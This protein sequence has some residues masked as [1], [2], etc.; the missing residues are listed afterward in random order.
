LGLKLQ[1]QKEFI[2]PKVNRSFGDLLH[3]MQKKRIPPRF[4]THPQQKRRQEHTPKWSEIS[5]FAPQNYM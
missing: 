3:F 5:N 4:F 1:N 2:S